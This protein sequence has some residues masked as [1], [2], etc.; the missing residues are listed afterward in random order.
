VLYTFLGSLPWCFVLAYAGYKLGQHW[1]D[2]GS[3]LHKY[4]AVVAVIA[5]ILIGI[6]LYRHLG[7]SRD[8]SRPD[9]ET[10]T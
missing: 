2:V 8:E 4:D 3:T 10:G 6:F 9:M 7:R 5:I 1:E